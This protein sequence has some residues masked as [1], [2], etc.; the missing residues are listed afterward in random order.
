[1]E[2]AWNFL[3]CFTDLDDL[4][5]T[6]DWFGYNNSTQDIFSPYHYR[7]YIIEFI[8]NEEYTP[9]EFYK[10]EQVINNIFWDLKNKLCKYIEDNETKFKT[11][12]HDMDSKDLV[13]L[14]EEYKGGGSGINS[15]CHFNEEDNKWYVLSK[16]SNLDIICMNVMMDE[17]K[18]EYYM[19]YPKEIQAYK[20]KHNTYY[21]MN[22]AFPNVNPIFYNNNKKATWIN[23]INKMYYYTESDK[24]EYHKDDKYWYQL[25]K[26]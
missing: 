10:C 20:P 21:A 2:E 18:Y 24:F 15:Y 11:F 23:K 17:E 25:I 3:R 9:D 5:L 14:K 22:Y 1:M 16:L 12:E 8:R 13:Q 19:L 26:D 7:K 6:D 4:N